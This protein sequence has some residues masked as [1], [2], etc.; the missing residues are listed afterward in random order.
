VDEVGLGQINQLGADVLLRRNPQLYQEV[1]TDVLG[2][3]ELPYALLEEEDQAL[4][5]GA[6]IGSMSSV[7]PDCPHGLDLENARHSIKLISQV[8]KA[9]CE[10]VKL[11]VDYYQDDA[12]VDDWE[13]PYEDYWKFTLFTYHSGISCFENTVEEIFNHDEL[14]NWENFTNR[15]TECDYGVDYVDGLWNNILAFETYRYTVTDQ[16]EVAFASVFAPTKT[17]FPT[18]VLSTAQVVVQVFI[19]ANQ[20]G[21]AEASEWVDGVSVNLRAE[22]GME[23]NAV[24]VDGRAVFDLS[25]FPANMEAVVSLPG[26]YRSE[27]F[28][29]PAQGVVTLDFVF[30]EPILPTEIP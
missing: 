24:T 17:P 23:L 15:V 13:D 20:N 14:I 10:T 25:D 3:C 9:N 29:I 7:C 19:D 6:L 12:L 16:D 27:T 28:E 5:R 30:G 22:N 4:L 2:Y 18:P 8:V 26:L 21:V 11:V 1:C